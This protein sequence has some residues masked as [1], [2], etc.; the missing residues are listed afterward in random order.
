MK[1]NDHVYIKNKRGV[2]DKNDPNCMGRVTGIDATHVYITNM[3]MP[4]L[5]TFAHKPIPKDMIV[6]R[7]P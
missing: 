4:Y 1:I 3:N 5:G 7:L 2:V 6:E